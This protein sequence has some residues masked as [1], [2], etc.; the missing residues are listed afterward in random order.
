M[1]IILFIVTVAYATA[2]CMIIAGTW[3]LI[4]EYFKGYAINLILKVLALIAVFV[5]IK[6]WIYTFFKVW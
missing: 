3:L 5:L 4:D 6:I 2:L 1:N